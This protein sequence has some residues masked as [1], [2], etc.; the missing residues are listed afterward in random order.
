LSEDELH[1]EEEVQIE[2]A[3][4]ATAAAPG[5]S[6]SQALF[7]REQKLLDEMTQIAEASRGAPDARIRKLVDW[8]RANMC[9]NLPRAGEQRSG[10]AQWNNIRIIIFTEW[11]DTQRYLFQQLSAAIEGTD[12]A[13]DRVAI[14]HGPT[15]VDE[16]ERIK[17]A[18]NA[19]PSKHPVRILIATDAAREGLNLQAHCWNPSRM[20][21]R[22]GRID[23]SFKRTMQSALGLGPP[24]SPQH[25]GSLA[26][27]IIQTVDRDCLRRDRSP[28]GVA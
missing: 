18:F 5:D 9:P 14:Y 26:T 19:D 22:N 13:D 1:A 11:D 15:P 2:A 21:Q 8:M 16:R 23:R 7:Q 6:Q 28:N 24:R 4:S 10:T 17:R 27:H 20:E 12:R 25:D 3:T